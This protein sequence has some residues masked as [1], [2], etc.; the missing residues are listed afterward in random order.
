ML[1]NFI[2]A[3][4]F[5]MC[6]S[7]SLPAQTESGESRKPHFDPAKL[8][9][10]RQKNLAREKS[11]LH[12]TATQESAWQS[13]VEKTRLAP[14]PPLPQKNEEKMSEPQR[15]EKALAHLQDVEVK[16]QA[17]LSALKEFYSQLSPE[18]KT[19]FDLL[20]HGGGPGPGGFPFPPFVD[21]IGPGAGLP[22][23]GFGAPPF[24][25]GLPPLGPGSPPFGPWMQPFAP[26]DVHDGPENTK[27]DAGASERSQA[28]GHLG[29]SAKANAHLRILPGTEPPRPVE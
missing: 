24:R 13:F 18:Q 2:L 20:H 21:P 28:T 14:P 22:P 23:P 26:P 11:L 3:V 19:I 25:L 6:M 17:H 27:S 7:A 8:E 9:E 10:W 16:M 29:S 12:L 15:L 5:C 4:P 1:R